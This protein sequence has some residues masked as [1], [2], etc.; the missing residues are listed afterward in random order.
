MSTFIMDVMQ[1]QV[2][3]IWQQANACKTAI[4]LREM[5]SDTAE[6]LGVNSNLTN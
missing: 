6:D 4:P 2:N 3:G 1:N 5:T